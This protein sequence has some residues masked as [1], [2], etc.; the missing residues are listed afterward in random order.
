VGFEIDFLPVGDSNGD[1]ICIRYGDGTHGYSIHIVDGAF[2]ETGDDI[3][4]HIRTYYHPEPYVRHVVLSH[5]CNDH[6]PGLIRV[7]EQL[8]V[9]TLWMNIPWLYATHTLEHFHGNYT[10]EGAIK[11]MKEKHEYLVRLEEVAKR[12][13]RQVKEVFQGQQIGPFLVLAPSVQ[14]YISLVPFL[15]KTPET[16]SDAKN[17]FANLYGKVQEAVQ[18]FVEERWDIETL[19][20]NPGAT[21]ASNESC[22][23]QLGTFGDSSVLLT[24][25]VGPDGLAEAAHYAS[26]KGLLRSPNF[27]QVPHHGSRHN[28]T[29]RVL[30]W[31]L[32][33]PLPDFNGPIRGTAYCSV[34]RTSRNIRE[35]RSPTHSS[36]ADT[37]LRARVRSSSPFHVAW[38]IDPAGSPSRSNPS[39]TK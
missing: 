34:G 30:D 7:L 16:Y 18:N 2:I 24:A 19:S 11:Y 28:V 23:V 20:N 22:V 25:D 26:E 32:G 33:K 6:A 13:G 17:P 10:L 8:Q 3:V 14:R 29:P 39:T 38:P 15:D 4:E 21:S 27:V 5:A 35:R 37:A 36:A 9:G 31:W 1:A 12:K